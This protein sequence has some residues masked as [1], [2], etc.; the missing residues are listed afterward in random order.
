V[1]Q[2]RGADENRMSN[3]VSEGN[4]V[5]VTGLGLAEVFRDSLP[6]GVLVVDA[7]D[8]VCWMNPAAARL[9]GG[10]PA[11]WIGRPT[12]SLPAPLM[13]LVREP[14]P[15][16]AQESECDLEWEDP[17][18]G[19]ILCRATVAGLQ[20]PGGVQLRWLTLHDLRPLER[21]EREL[22]RLDRLANI[23][24]L[25]ASVAHEI[26]NA[27]VAIKTFVELAQ[28]G[29]KPGEL[30]EVAL[31][32]LKRIET[33]ILQMLRFTGG[34]R[35]QAGRV[36]LRDILEH[37][38]RLI[39]EPLKLKAIRLERRY[40]TEQDWILGN[41]YQLEQAFVNL[42]IN[43][44]ESMTTGGILTLEIA[45][46]GPSDPTPALREGQEPGPLLRV[47]VAD[48][49]SGIAPENLPRV[50]EPFFTTKREGTGL[51]LAITRR[52]FE[53]HQAAVSVESRLHHGTAFHVLFP[54]APPA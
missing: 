32:E 35:Q 22:V 1:E 26:K 28:S 33:I 51:G 14:T 21:A 38:L 47:T 9:L 25:A 2:S 50:F 29:E 13:A 24:T 49:G 17:Q 53:E 18:L 34:P 3:S 27:L 39:Q 23:G 12:A 54:P 36:R 43:A 16:R 8:R 44:V 31:R 52:I 15:E 19:R 20:A 45:P 48:T 41:E 30:G 46:A 4:G 40:A 5:A 37:S 6:C 42:L 7:A 11:D 10:Q